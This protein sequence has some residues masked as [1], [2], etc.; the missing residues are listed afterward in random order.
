MSLQR[1]LPAKTSKYVQVHIF[2]KI[3]FYFKFILQKELQMTLNYN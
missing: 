1:F 3:V 2:Y